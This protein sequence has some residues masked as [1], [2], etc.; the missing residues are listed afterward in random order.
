[1]LYI[2]YLVS[3]NNYFH[4]SWK[5]RKKHSTYNLY[6]MI[7]S[8]FIFFVFTLSD[9]GSKLKQLIIY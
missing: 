8:T 4:F 6:N 3:Y 7:L 1:M 9:E 5:D 2:F